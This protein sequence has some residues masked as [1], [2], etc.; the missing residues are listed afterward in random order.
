LPFDLLNIA[1]CAVAAMLALAAGVASAQPAQP[2]TVPILYIE[3]QVERPPVLSNLIAIPEDEGEQ[4]ARLAISD[5]NTTGQFLN[6]TYELQE[7][8]V[9]LEDDLTAT[10]SGLLSGGPKL[11]VLNM[12]ADALKVVAALPEAADDL[13]FNAGSTDDDLRGEACSANLLHTLPSRSMLA[14]ALIQFLA[15]KR[16]TEIMLITGNRAD[17]EA[18]ADAI[19]RS[20]TKFGL[21]IAHERPWLEDADLRRNAAQEI[22][23]F[24]QADSYDVVIVADEADDFAPY[25]QYNTWLPRPVAGSAGIEP[26]AWSRVLEQWG[27]AQLQSR[28]ESQADRPMRSIDYAA[29]AAIRS[30]GEAVTRTS[31]NGV[32]DIRAYLLSNAFS[33]AAFKGAAISYRAWNGQ[34]RQPIPLASAEALVALAPIEG[35]L[36]QTTE[37]D[38]LGFDAPETTCPSMESEQ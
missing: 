14:D 22:P 3:E 21:E 13:L 4:G 35:F 1:P 32:A 15:R 12:S 9:G 19:R 23:V 29:W 28:F 33:L 7:V 36:H 20:A 38:T 17:D 5:N 18:F 10:V 37:L 2:L 8:V 31:G 30:I 24:T 25:V 27:A 26:V 16:W 34:L 6:H 11:A